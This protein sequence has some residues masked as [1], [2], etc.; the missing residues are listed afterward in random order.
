[1]KDVKLK[2]REQLGYK[3]EPLQ[4]KKVAL[5]KVDHEALQPTQV[6]ARKPRLAFHLPSFTDL[7][8]QLPPSFVRRD[9]RYAFFAN[10]ARFSRHAGKA[11]F[12]A[13]ILDRSLA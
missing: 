8:D 10:N 6:I 11:K 7:F 13:I 3:A 2:I 4:N 9:D 5:A 12:G 1:M